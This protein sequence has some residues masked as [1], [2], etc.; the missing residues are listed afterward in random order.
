MPKVSI[1]VP[2]YNT[3]KYVRE[4]IDSIVNQSL[5]DIEI[6]CVDD[7]STDSSAAILDEYANKDSRIRV[8]HKENSGYGSSMNR[9]LDE[10][11]GE[12]FG[13]VDSDD[14]IACDMYRYLYEKAVTHELD[15]VRSDHYRWFPE[16][17]AKRLNYFYATSGLYNTVK[18]PL[19][20]DD[21]FVR[22]VTCTGLY[23]TSFIRENEIRYHETPGAAF[24]DQGFWLQ[25]TAL[26]KR[27]MF[28]DRGFYYYRFDNEAS[29]I[30]SPKAIETMDREYEFFRD[31]AS[32]HPDLSDRFSS[33]YWRARF[34]MTL[35]SC[36]QMEDDLT[37]ELV[38]PFYESFRQAV[39]NKEIDTSLFLEDQL[40]ML[41]CLLK[42]PE[43]FC[44]Q[45]IGNI[46]WNQMIR[47]CRKKPGVVRKTVFHVRAF[48]LKSLIQKF[49]GNA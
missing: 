4:C 42:G 18:C 2:V 32:A 30:H 20:S 14:C 21:L 36:Q 47:K 17:A 6:I 1:I 34:A 19:E 43:Y 13:L 39:Q 25:T 29:S 7:G 27:V 37:P 11:T 44:S 8:I 12:Y 15:F 33:F 46:K 16:R 35:F 41:A 5:K 9:A 38:Q 3:E 23:K 10:I 24:Q 45:Q 28:V 26:A 49:C 40:N 31:Y 48:G 22:I